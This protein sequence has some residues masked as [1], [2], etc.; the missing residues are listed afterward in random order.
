MSEGWQA[1]ELVPRTIPHC[2]VGLRGTGREP[3]WL[4]WDSSHLC[5]PACSSPP[6]PLRPTPWPW[7][8]VT[9]SGVVLQ[10]QQPVR[11]GDGVVFDAGRPQEAEQGGAIYDILSAGGSRGAS[12]G[13]LDSASPGKGEGAGN[14]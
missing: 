3:G 4:T 8:Q 9:R 6:C 1:Q 10:L 7:P 14:Q 11:R 13:G 12:G 2:L 5:L